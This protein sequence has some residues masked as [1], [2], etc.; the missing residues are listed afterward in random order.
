MHYF[1]GMDIGGTNI[2]ACILDAD[3]N[4]I[5]KFKVSNNVAL[6][7]D[8]NI[9]DVCSKIKEKWSHY[10]IRAIGV[11]SPGP[12]DL[13][14]GVL[15]TPP[16]LPGWENFELKSFIENE[17]HLPVVVNNDANVAA[18]SEA[19]IGAG[20][21]CESVYYITLSTGVGGGFIYNGHIINGFNNIAAEISNM[22]INEDTYRHAGLNCG[23]LEGQCSGE[24]IRR[25][26]SEKC[27]MPM[28]TENVFNHAQNGNKEC[29]Q[30]LN[31]WVLNISKAIANIAVVVD[32]EMFVL[33]GSV[34]LHNPQYLEKIQAAVNE[35]VFKSVNINIRLAQIGDDTGLIGAGI[36]ASSLSD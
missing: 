13:K 26:A 4:I 34:I 18:Y 7:P 28:T 23:G 31:N 12:L 20:K 35:L 16:N 25:M 2:R 36:L 21:N 10:N 11:G 27:A 29:K 14:K 3:R 30:I 33:G 22:I 17:F 8:V 19:M 15:L 1:I 24:S 32:P 6:G 9:R 5:D